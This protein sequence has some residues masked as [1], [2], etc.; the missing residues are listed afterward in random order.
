MRMSLTSAAARPTP[1]VSDACALARAPA[2]VVVAAGKG[3]NGA[4]GKFAAVFE[5]P[6]VG[7]E[8]HLRSAL[9]QRRGKRG[10]RKEMAARAAGREQD[11]ARRAHSAGAT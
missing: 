11:R 2:P 7:R 9:G 5:R 8:L 1:K 6:A 10:C 4:G 3:V